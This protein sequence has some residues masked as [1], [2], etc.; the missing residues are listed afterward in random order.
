MS[1][2]ERNWIGVCEEERQSGLPARCTQT[3]RRSIEVDGVGAAWIEAGRGWIGMY[4]YHHIDFGVG[5][6]RALLYGWIQGRSRGIEGDQW[7]KRRRG[8][9]RVIM[10]GLGCQA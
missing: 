10:V 3:E 1:D 4:M 6:W 5:G 7:R 2:K 9:R 8:K